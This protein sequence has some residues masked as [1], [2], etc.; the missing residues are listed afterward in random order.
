MN[1]YDA[2]RDLHHDA[3]AHSWGAKMAKGDISQAEYWH[4]LWNLWLIHRDLDEYMPA[5]SR[6][7]MALGWDMAKTDCKATIVAQLAVGVYDFA[8]M[9]DAERGGWAYIM[10]GAHFRG[11]AVIRKRMEPKGFSCQHLR[12]ED[13][14]KVNEYL[15][16]LRERPE[17][18]E[19]ARAAFKAIIEIMNRIEQMSASS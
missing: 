17:C 2:T 5:E 19:G 9:S 1:L 16:S 13:P 11:G 14:A 3:E 7:G 6:R 18:A 12:F 15:V 10:I 4:W 8:N